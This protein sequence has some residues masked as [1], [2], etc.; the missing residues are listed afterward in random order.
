M[1]EKDNTEEERTKKGRK[2]LKRR[3]G[4]RKNRIM[5]RGIIWS[6]TGRGKWRIKNEQKRKKKWDISGRQALDRDHLATEV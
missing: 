5:K 6:E 3:D 2:G 1:K 4:S